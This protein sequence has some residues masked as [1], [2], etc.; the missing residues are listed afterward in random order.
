[1]G[2]H[3]NSETGQYSVCKAGKKECPFVYGE[4]LEDAQSAYEKV[5]AS[6][7]LTT[8]NKKQ[9]SKDY[10]RSMPAE[11]LSQTPLKELD[12]AQLVQT[13]R[14]EMVKM[15]IYDEN[16]DSAVNLATIL[17]SHQMRGN[18][19]NFDKTP[20]IEHPLRNA[21]RLIRLGV[22]NKDVIIATVLH[23]TIEDGAKVFVEK[24]KNFNKEESTELGARDQ[25]G[26][27]IE[28]AYGKK[29]LSLVDAVTND[30]IT[31]T[32]KSQMS[33]EEKNKIYRDHVSENIVKSPEVF[34]VKVSDFIDNATGLYHNDIPSRSEKTLKQAKKYLPVVKIFQDT[35]KNMNLP[36][37]E[38]GRTSITSHLTKTEIRLKK[39]IEKYS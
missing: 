5:M 34:L 32:D 14:H 36:I 13:M 35:M 33:T 10:L 37:T 28:Q 39:I 30:Y 31:D 22:K 17:H 21:V 3:Y 15:G 24:F 4:T 26:N 20:Y 8:I 9:P 7:I 38:E 12:T 11:I 19:G 18:R 1:M 2:Y 29:V 27:H 25:L 16:V 23:D 6:Q